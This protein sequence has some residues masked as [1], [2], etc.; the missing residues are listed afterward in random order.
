MS[1]AIDNWNINP[2]QQYFTKLSDSGSNILVELFN[3]QAEAEADTNRVAY[4]SADYG[5]SIEL[6]LTN[7]ITD[8][9]IE[10]FNSMISYHLKVSGES[11]DETKI[12]HVKEFTDLDEISSPLFT[13]TPIIQ[14]RASHEINFHTHIRVERSLRLANHDPDICNGQVLQI[15]SDMRSLDVLAEVESATILIAQTNDGRT[16]ITEQ[17]ETI[18][19]VDFAK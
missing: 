16:S 13:S 18:Q 2:N 19:Y 4:G 1:F 8:P 7:D 5:S 17:L 10:Y 15:Q 12:F 11:G 6:E 3:T 9:E 14:A